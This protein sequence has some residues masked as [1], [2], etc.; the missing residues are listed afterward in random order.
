MAT[1]NVA[2]A[3]SLFLSS[4]QIPKARVELA[5]RSLAL[6]SGLG[7]PFAITPKPAT[8]APTEPGQRHPRGI[9]NNNPGNIRWDGRT[10]WRGMVGLDEGRYVIFEAPVWGLSAMVS[11]LR[12]G[13]S[14]DQQNTIR[15]IVTEWAPPL[16]ND[17]ESYIRSVSAQ[18]GL[19]PDQALAEDAIP[20]LLQAI[21][22][23]EN[24]N[25]PY[26]DELIEQAIA[27]T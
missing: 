9:R 13:L 16:E 1:L 27:L 25:I 24:G 19:P 11:A 8:K 22:K 17:T 20:A 14:H 4:P 7:T 23:H 26:S 18:T 15:G 10:Q 21:V 6:V 12:A 2:R 5:R 3:I